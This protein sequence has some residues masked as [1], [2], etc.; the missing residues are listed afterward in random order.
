MEEIEVIKTNTNYEQKEFDKFTNHL[1]LMKLQSKINSARPFALWPYPMPFNEVQESTK[2]LHLTIGDVIDLPKGATLKFL[3]F[4]NSLDLTF[5]NPENIPFAPEVFFNS[6]YI[7]TYIHDRCLC[8][9]LKFDHEEEFNNFE[10]YMDHDGLWSEL[11]VE[12]SSDE[13]DDII[14]TEHQR[15]LNLKFKNSMRIGWRGPVILLDHLKYL[16]EIYKQRYF[17]TEMITALKTTI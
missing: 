14:L 2:F 15:F 7:A 13:E 12:T 17:N 9:K 16:P 10:F 1:K 4:A 5:D 11:F 3:C 8:G 6:C